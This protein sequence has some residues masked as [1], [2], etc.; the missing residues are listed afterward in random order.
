M[1]IS[2][3]NSFALSPNARSL[4]RENQEGTKLLDA[5]KKLGKRASFEKQVKGQLDPISQTAFR[6]TGNWDTAEEL[7]QETMLRAVRNWDSFREQ[8]HFKTWLYRILIN[9]FRDQIRR[10]KNIS[11]T[12]ETEELES[13]EHNVHSQAEANELSELV[14]QLIS[15]LPDRQKEVLILSTYESLSNQQVAETLNVSVANVHANL[16]LARKRLKEQLANYLDGR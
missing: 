15:K 12:E 3:Q 16:S 4:P 5:M 14:N 8:A 7:V 13:R 6:L 2:G 1:K 10:R 11:T 9:A